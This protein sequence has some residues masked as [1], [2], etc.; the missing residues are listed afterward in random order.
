L[1]RQWVAREE[2]EA[3][4]LDCRGTVYPVNVGVWATVRLPFLGKDIDAEPSALHDPDHN[5]TVLRRRKDVK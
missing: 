4:K 1:S 2:R 3:G 5:E